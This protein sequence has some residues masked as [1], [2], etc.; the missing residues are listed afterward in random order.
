MKRSEDAFDEEFGG[1]SSISSER[2]MT[3]KEKLMLAKQRAMEK[4]DAKS[5]VSSSGA[6]SR[7]EV[8]VEDKPKNGKKNKGAKLPAIQENELLERDTIDL[9]KRENDLNDP[10]AVNSFRTEYENEVSKRMNHGSRKVLAPVDYTFVESL[11][12]WEKKSVWDI[13]LKGVL[14]EKLKVENFRLI[15]R[16]VV[17]AVLSGKDV[18]C[19]MPTG[20]GKSLIFLASG[21]VR[22]GFTVIIMPIISLIQDQM[23]K[24]EDLGIP[25][26]S[27]TSR[28]GVDSKEVYSKLSLAVRE[29]TTNVKF[30]FTTPEKFS[31]GTA[32]K[33]LLIK[34]YSFGMIQRF[35]IDEAHCVSGWG[36]EFRPDYLV[37]QTFKEVFPKCQ[38]LALTATATKMVREDVMRIL[39]MDKPLYF[40]S[41]FNRTNLRYTVLRKTSRETDQLINLLELYRG[42][43]GIIYC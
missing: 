15:Q 9:D 24:M 7:G 11:E 6:S 17:N 10:Y 2:P 26:L 39:K 34:A 31:M 21:L 19:C 36:H 18:F 12:E 22:E 28:E 38:I 16:P 20:G 1:K 30:L 4:K 42:M 27:T 32:F 41:S 35:V 29:R 37:L 43:T 14:K 3:A 25:Y 23:R 40:Q 33:E 8:S 5:S 13:P